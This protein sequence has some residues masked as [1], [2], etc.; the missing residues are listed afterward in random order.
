MANG[1]S[2]AGKPV[3][4]YTGTKQGVT[5]TK[6]QEGA[7][8]QCGAN[9]CGAHLQKPPQTESRGW[10]AKVAQA[11]R[12]YA[13]KGPAAAALPQVDISTLSAPDRKKVA[14]LWKSFGPKMVPMH[15]DW[16]STHGSGGTRG[17]GS[18]EVFM[19]FH[20]N[21]MKD[22]SKVIETKDPALF[23]K[24]NGQ[25]PVWDTTKALPKEFQFPDM[26]PKMKGPKGIDWK[27]PAYLSAKGGGESF[28]LKDA[29][30]PKTIKSLNDIKSADELGRVLGASGV[31]A[32][33]HI[34]LGGKMGGFASI[35]TPPFQL[36]H[37]KMEEIRKEW[38]TTPSGKAAAKAHPP[39]GFT[40]PNANSHAQAMRAQPRGLAGGA[41]PITDHEFVNEMRQLEKQQKRASESQ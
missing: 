13:P 4:V 27:P 19:Q 31:H 38:L 34:R 11:G 28:V 40:D 15:E 17:P 33:G 39:E 6:P 7:Q 26:D 35:A 14:D 32:V 23:K 8:M 21:L 41:R 36:W 1:V 25:L 20:A 30:P 16:H 9:S 5:S 18:G 22:F 24:L 10:S 3:P 29:S 12:A 37:G 2:G